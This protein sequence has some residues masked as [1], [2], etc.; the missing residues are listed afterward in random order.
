M[1]YNDP[2]RTNCGNIPGNY[3]P[4][5]RHLTCADV[6]EQVETL[7]EIV[8]VVVTADRLAPRGP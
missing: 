4:T 5:N 2:N 6:P 8:T 1:Y 3:P 7:P